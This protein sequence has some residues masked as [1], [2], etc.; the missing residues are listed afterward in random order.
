MSRSDPIR[1]NY[2]DVVQ[3]GETCAAWLFYANLALS[4]GEKW[5]RLSEQFYP[6]R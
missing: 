4:F 6:E 2:F 3:T 1:A 5:P